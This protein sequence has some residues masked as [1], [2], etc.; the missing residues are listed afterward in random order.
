VNGDMTNSQ[1]KLAPVPGGLGGLEALIKAQSASGH[2]PVHLWNPPYCG[3]I[4]MRIARDGTW[5]YQGS[6]I[7]R[8]PL[9]KLFASV[10][11]KDADG[12]HYL[13][14]PV[15]KIGVDI[16]DAPFLAV[17][18]TVTG[19]DRDQVL[20]FRSNV[21]DAVDC[22]PVHGLRFADD[23]LTGGRKPYVNMRA[24]LEALVTRAV[25]YDL[26]ALGE[27]LEIDGVTQFGVWSG[28]MFFPMADAAAVQ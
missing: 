18:M 4:G 2:P 6:P 26:V 9:V 22:G 1:S 27:T 12:R 19:T 5:Y 15:E 16:D 14:T 11:R 13:V 3:E 23:G 10:L 24:G 7:G 17:E 25:Y 21:D 20:R 8:A 28:G